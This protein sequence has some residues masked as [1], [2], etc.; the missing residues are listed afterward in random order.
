LRECLIKL[1]GHRDTP[2]TPI[3]S[4]TADNEVSPLALKPLDIGY[5][6]DDS[7]NTPHRLYAL[8]A[9]ELGVLLLSSPPPSHDNNNDNNDD[10]SSHSHGDVTDRWDE[11]ITW[12]DRCID[13]CEMEL[14]RLNERSLPSSSTTSTS[15]NKTFMSTTKTINKNNNDT[16]ANIIRNGESSDTL[17]LLTL[18]SQCYDRCAQLHSDNDR[19]AEC[20]ALERRRLASIIHP[21]HGWLLP[22]AKSTSS[23]NGTPATALSYEGIGHIRM[24]STNTLFVS[25]WINGS[26]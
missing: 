10:S 4:S 6:N 12:F 1:D 16:A 26:Q 9:F 13:T 19:W 11:A 14:T 8:A 23:S 22:D 20:E 7:L 18:I 17:P 24:A 15:D 25:K 5:Y 2:I 3:T 21:T